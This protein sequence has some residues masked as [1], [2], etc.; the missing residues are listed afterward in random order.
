MYSEIRI[1]RKKE[2]TLIKEKNGTWI[3]PKK[4]KN[5]NIIY[6]I[7]PE[8]LIVKLKVIRK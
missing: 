7:F 4:I 3:L 6:S 1:I 8:I 2:Y 5:K